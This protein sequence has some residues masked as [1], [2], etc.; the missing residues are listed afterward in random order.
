MRVDPQLPVPEGLVRV[1]ARVNEIKSRFARWD[2]E[3]RLRAAAGSR[4]DS[5]AYDAEIA[6]AAAREGLDPGLLK[7]LV[8]AESGFN[9]NAV[10]RAG[11]QGL[12]QLMPGTAAALGVA[13]PFDP[14]QNLAGG[15][16]YLRQQLDRFGDLEPALAA[17]NAGPAAVVRYGG[18][19]PFPE[20]QAYV[21]NVL[22]YLAEQSP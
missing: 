15:A 2:F 22:G 4:G 5:D 14:R 3:S 6:E 12:T 18:V 19:P 8:R 7:A 1:Q 16:R 20:T 17:Y 10:S 13:N 11:A 9:A 21:T